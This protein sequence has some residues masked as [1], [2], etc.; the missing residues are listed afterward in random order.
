[1]AEKCF[2]AGYT[3]DSERPCMF[4]PRP[5]ITQAMQPER[6]WWGALAEVHAPRP[7]PG[8]LGK[9]PRSLGCSVM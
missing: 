5:A 3:A 9:P 2:T 7:G 4:A 8:G 6:D 1:M